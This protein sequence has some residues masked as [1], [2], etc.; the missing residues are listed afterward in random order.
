[1]AACP[2]CQS[3][4]AEVTSSRRVPGAASAT[5][6]VKCPV[7]PIPFEIPGQSLNV[8]AQNPRQFEQRRLQWAAFLRGAVERGEKMARLY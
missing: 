6:F 8:A 2:V 3:P 4:F 5:W 7:C 1:M